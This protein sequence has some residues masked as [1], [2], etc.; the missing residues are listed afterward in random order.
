MAKARLTQEFSDPN[1]TEAKK[2]IEFE[3]EFSFWDGPF[4]GGY[5]S[6]GDRNSFQAP[7]T[8][9]KPASF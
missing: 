1:D 6:S 2:L 8:T 5:V 4:S 9:T 3:D 7:E